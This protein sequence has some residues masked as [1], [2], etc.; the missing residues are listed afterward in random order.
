MGEAGPGWLATLRGYE[1][2]CI[3][4]DETSLTTPG[5]PLAPS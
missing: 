4:A 3:L 5:F 2:L 1:A